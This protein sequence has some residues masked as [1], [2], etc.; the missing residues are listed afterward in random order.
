MSESAFLST[1]IK[2][3]KDRALEFAHELAAAG[4]GVSS[5]KR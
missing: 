4:F 2:E 5:T 3:L 1:D